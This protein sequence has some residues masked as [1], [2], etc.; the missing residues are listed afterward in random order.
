MV[1]ARVSSIWEGHSATKRDIREA[2]PSKKTGRR[3]V[4]FL[5]SYPSDCMAACF[6]TSTAY[7]QHGVLDNHKNIGLCCCNSS[8]FRANQSVSKETCTAQGLPPYRLYVGDEPAGKAMGMGWKCR[9]NEFCLV[10]CAKILLEMLLRPSHVLHLVVLRKLG[11]LQRS[12]SMPALAAGHP[13][14]WILGLIIRL[15]TRLPTRLC[16]S[17]GA[18]TRTS[19][20]LQ[21]LEIYRTRLIRVKEVEG[22]SVHNF[23]SISSWMTACRISLS[24]AKRRRDDARQGSALLPNFNTGHVKRLDPESWLTFL[25]SWSRR[26]H[27]RTL[28]CPTAPA[29]YD[30]LPMLAK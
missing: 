7:P 2:G 18:T 26:R 28:L 13:A 23:L 17:S 20:S 24:T 11:R 16:R 25:N 15:V 21:L 3:Y 8:L 14:P 9:A 19:P 1:K 4:S 22:L 6:H 10:H 30:G 12:D 29:S 5:L 27:L